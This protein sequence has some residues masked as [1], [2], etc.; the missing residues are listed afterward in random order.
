MGKLKRRPN[1]ILV[2]RFSIL[3]PK[4]TLQGPKK[5]EKMLVLVFYFS[6]KIL[7]D[8]SDEKLEMCI[9]K[10]VFGIFGII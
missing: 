1:G 6:K 5:G 8:C 10:N 7:G 9:Q 3:G 2:V 4:T